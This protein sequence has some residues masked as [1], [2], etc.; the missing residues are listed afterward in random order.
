MFEKPQFLY[1]YCTADRA[2]QILQDQ[3]LYLCPPKDLNDLYEGSL[4]RMLKYT[5]EI[6]FELRWRQIRC[7]AGWDEEESKSFV[8][9]NHDPEEARRNFDYTTDRLREL[10]ALSRQ[11]SG[12]ICFSERRDDQRMWGTYGDNHQGVCIEFVNHGQSSLIERHC[13][14][15]LYSN[16]RLDS[17]LP[18]LMQEDGSLDAGLFAFFCYFRK[19]LDWES[20]R[21]WRILMLANETQT[22]ESRRMRFSNEDVKRIF[23]GPR[24][25]EEHLARIGELSFGESRDWG[26]FKL[27]PNSDLGRT[28]FEG[29]ESVKSFD[30]LKYWIPALRTFNDEPN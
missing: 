3:Y 12:I 30:D 25:R 11:H 2:I 20:E 23:V 10:N 15:V 21:E 29:V 16:E 6:G 13:L 1:K 28:E 7:Y 14:P 17:S 9:E 5:P 26:I 22:M 8:R 24:I 18:E 4:G 19:T 27:R